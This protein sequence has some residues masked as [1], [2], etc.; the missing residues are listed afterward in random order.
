[1]PRLIATGLLLSQCIPTP[2][3]LLTPH[4][5]MQCLR[6]SIRVSL[7]E[8]IHFRFSGRH[9][10]VT[11][12]S[13]TIF[14][15]LSFRTSLL[16]S[17][18]HSWNQ[19]AMLLTSPYLGLDSYKQSRRKG[20]RNEQPRGLW[21]STHFMFPSSANPS[22]LSPV[23]PLSPPP[24]LPPIPRSAESAGVLVTLLLYAKKRHK[25]A[26]FALSSITAPATDV[27]TKAVRK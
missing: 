4:F 22:D 3:L 24:T 11:S 9:L 20:L 26:Q 12:S 5:L 8:I 2:R 1:M 14:L 16:T 18:L 6:S 27:L 19:S 7:L 17:S 15:F 23:P 10:Q 13:F 21:Q 25:L